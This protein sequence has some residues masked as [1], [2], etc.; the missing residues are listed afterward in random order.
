MQRLPDDELQR[1]LHE[2]APYGDLTTRALGISTARAVLSFA[3]RGAMRVAAVE[4]AAR[5]FELCGALA[6][7]RLP[8]GADAAPGDCL[9]QAEGA[10]ADLLRAW[11]VA[12]TAV[13]A[14]SGIATE[15]ARIVGLL[16]AAG[17]GLPLACTRKTWPGGRALA[18][19]AVWAGGA[20]MHR[21]GLSETLLVFPEHRAFLAADQVAAHFAR[22]R[23]SQPEKKLVV[24][25]GSED[26]AL[27]LA[28][29]GAEVLQL[30]RFSPPAVAAL[31]QRLAAEGLA[32]L[33]APAGG[34]TAA[35]ALAHACAG[36]DL[37][38]SSAPYF[39]PPA[40]VQVKIGPAPRA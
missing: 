7:V 9:L 17:Y 31:R 22:L 40:D 32:V 27:A 37:L 20:V 29:A 11:K 10:A 18:A 4:E 19:R 2:D 33:L 28:R 1:W 13:E 35:N 6:Q 3:A 30:E 8:S 38:V 5:L 25:V 36:A 39:A 23:R 34:V 24:E 15:A 14:A 26:E 12:Q 21:L 16:R